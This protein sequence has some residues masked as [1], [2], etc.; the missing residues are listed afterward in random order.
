MAPSLAE[1]RQALLQALQQRKASIVSSQLLEAERTA[2]P[3]SGGQPVQWQRI[4]LAAEVQNEGFNLLVARPA[5]PGQF[6]AVV[7]MHSTGKC[8]EYLAA[9]GAMGPKGLLG[10]WL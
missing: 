7:L 4:K 10:S 2:A 3:Y 6:P 8:K 1:R 9:P 5:L